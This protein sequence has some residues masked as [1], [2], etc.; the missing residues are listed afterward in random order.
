MSGMIRGILICAISISYFWSA[1][2]QLALE[3]V[4]RIRNVSGLWL[5][6]TSIFFPKIQVYRSP[7]VHTM[8]YACFLMTDHFICDAVSFLQTNAMSRS[9][10]SM[11]FDRHAPS[12]YT[13]APVVTV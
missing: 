12:A 8:V 4:E 5:V 6:A 7:G 9:V 11:V 13:D 3:E 2:A 1:R 10:H